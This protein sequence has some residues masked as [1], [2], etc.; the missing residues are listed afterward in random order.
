MTTLEEMRKARAC[1][2]EQI[3]AMLTVGQ[4]AVAK[5]GKRTDMHVSNLR[6]HIEALGGRLEITAAVTRLVLINPNSNAAP[7]RPWRR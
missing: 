1:L 7:P 4:P 5:M 3:A 2:Q 6:R